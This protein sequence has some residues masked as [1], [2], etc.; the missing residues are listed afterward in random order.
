MTVE[1]FSEKYGVS[2]ASIHVAVY[3]KSVPK[4]VLYRPDGERVWH[5]K[6]DYFVKRLEFKQKV[7]RFIQ[8]MYYFHYHPWFTDG[9]IAEM[10]GVTQT[11][12]MYDMWAAQGE[13]IFRF[14]VPQ[15]TWKAFRKAR[16]PYRVSYKRY[17][18][19]FNL[20]QELDWMA[21][22]AS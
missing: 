21:G 19:S 8:D 6:E 14:K 10:W 5:I 13:S 22:I 16:I 3:N 12:L 17:D 4:S 1:E 20:T 2:R 18:P 15:A 11:Y 9:E 7:Y